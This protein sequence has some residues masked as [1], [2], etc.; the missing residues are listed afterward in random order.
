MAS[1]G[2]RKY[3]FPAKR[4]GW[5]WGFPSTWQG[6]AVLLVY[7]ALVMGG[8]PFVH[9]AKGSVVYVGYVLIVTAA[10]IAICWL[11]G[12]PPRWRWGERDERR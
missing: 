6:W 4:Y 7:L 5:G 10:L 11:T 9:I 3:W 2:A 8:I 1:V 12:E